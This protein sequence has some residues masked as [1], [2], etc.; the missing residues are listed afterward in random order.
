MSTTGSS[1]D[2]LMRELIKTGKK[3][4]AQL[5]RPKKAYTKADIR[6]HE[7]NLKG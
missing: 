1:V 2:A 4:K 5:G 7:R 6:K 3:R